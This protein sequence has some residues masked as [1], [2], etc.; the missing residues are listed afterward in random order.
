MFM[1]DIII[2]GSGPAGLSAGI[3]S[4][5]AG[6]KTLVIGENNSA[7]STAKKIDNYFGT[8][9]T[10]SGEE[11]LLKGKDQYLSE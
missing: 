5:R 8:G 10:V 1:F 2:I 6:A 4:V 7:L 3:Y 11:L 9:G